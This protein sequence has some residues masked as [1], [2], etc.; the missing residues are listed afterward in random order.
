MVLKQKNP[1]WTAK[2]KEDLKEITKYY[3]KE[4]SINMAHKKVKD[5][6][7]YAD[8]LADNP[9]LG[10]YEQALSS[11]PQGFRSLVHEHYKIIYFIEDDII[12][13]SAIFDCRQNPDI[14]Q[15]NNNKYELRIR[16]S[17]GSRTT[18]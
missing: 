7:H 6:K 4:I 3:K 1:Y 11:E 16:Q 18:C 10:F 12:Y 5:L 13:I 8:L 2:A 17:S 14:Y 15:I 9:L